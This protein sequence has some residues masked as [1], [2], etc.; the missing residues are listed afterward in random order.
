M[1]KLVNEHIY[2]ETRVID[3]QGI[4]IESPSDQP[5]NR[6]ETF[7]N[8][9]QQTYN[10]SAVFNRTRLQSCDQTISLY[11]LSVSIKDK[12]ALKSQIHNCNRLV[13]S[14]KKN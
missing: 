1:Q 12:I 14:I 6:S 13:K 3:Y 8:N 5:R 7:S 11:T 9:H 10:N 4:C 2:E